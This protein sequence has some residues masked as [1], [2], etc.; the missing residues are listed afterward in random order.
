MHLTFQEVQDILILWE[1]DPTKW[2][3]ARKIIPQEQVEYMPIPAV[4]SEA[5]KLT[6]EE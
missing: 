2:R 3:K 5:V 1:I 4:V 6:L